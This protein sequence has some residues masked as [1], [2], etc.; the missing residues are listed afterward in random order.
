MDVEPAC[1]QCG[2]PLLDAAVFCHRC[3]HRV[4][5][6][7]AP[8]VEAV[9]AAAPAMPQDPALGERRF[10][11][12]AVL[13]LVGYTAICSACDAED[14]QA[15]LTRFFALAD[16]TIL[17][18]GGHVVDHAGDAVIA[19]FGAPVAHGDDALRA[20]RAVLGLQARCGEV[21]DP[22]GRP[23]RLHAGCSSG[24]V[25]VSTISVGGRPQISVTGETLNVAARLAGQAGES[26]TLLS[27]RC[28]VLVEDRIDA[29]P[30][31][32]L[33]LKGLRAP[34]RAWRVHGLG[35]H[36]GASTRLLGRRPEL[37]CWQALLARTQGCDA[38]C[39]VGLEGPAGIGKSRLLE[40]FSGLASSAGHVV[41]KVGIVDFG[42]HDERQFLG[43]ILRNLSGIRPSATDSDAWQWTCD[44]AIAAESG[45]DPADAAALRALLRT[46]FG[47]P[48]D[49]SDRERLAAVPYATR[50]AW[51][52]DALASALAAASRERPLVLAIED[53]H[54]GS[55]TAHGL[56]VRAARRAAG[57]AWIMVYTTR[58]PIAEF[59]AGASDGSRVRHVELRL[60]PLQPEACA[61]LA[62]SMRV[63]PRERDACI[64][65]SGGNPL[66]LES[67]LRA[68]RSGP[69]DG[70]PGTVQAA[71]AARV[72]RLPSEL[73]SM[74]QVASV[75]GPSVSDE[76]LSRFCGAAAATA[77]VMDA[78]CRSGLLRRDGSRIAFGH[79][80]IHDAVYASLLNSRRRQ[81]HRSIADADLD[82]EPSL[83]AEHLLRAGDPRAAQA[84]LEAAR[85]ALAEHDPATAQTLAARG[86]T[87][88]P[89]PITLARLSIVRGSALCDIGR[90]AEAWG[91]L[92]EA[93]TI[94]AGR[95][96]L[97]EVTLA[98]VEVARITGRFDEAH[99]L[100]DSIE[101]SV[102]ASG[103]RVGI[104]SLHTLRGALL[105]AQA[106]PAESLA[107]HSRAKEAALESG[108]AQALIRA[109]SG[110]GDAEYGLGRWD[111][112]ASRFSE[113]YRLARSLGLHRHALPAA[114]MLGLV[115]M[116]QLR[117]Q[118]A[119]ETIERAL[120]EA[121]GRSTMLGEVVALNMLSRIRQVRGDL[122]D[123]E[124]HAHRAIRLA[125]L[126][127]ANRLESVALTLLASALVLSDRRSE[128]HAAALS[129]LEL[130][131]QYGLSFA[132]PN[133]F[134][135]I[136]MS[137]SS[138]ADRE[139]ARSE[140]EAILGRSD[141]VHAHIAFRKFAI[142]SALER[143]D[144]NEA[145]RH[146]AE[147]EAR[148]AP[149]G[150]AFVD[151]LVSRARGLADIGRA[152][153]NVESRR[154]L[155]ELVERIRGSG[156]L[157]LLGA[158]L[159][160]VALRVGVV[161]LEP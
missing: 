95:E 122:Q 27:D 133:A 63:D 7:G 12:C 111:D 84:F 123:A 132:G 131:R 54:W 28:H 42:V 109:L 83:R 147:L 87:A 140:G 153:A 25:V 31:E 96:V 6:L 154:C 47:L 33:M 113:A 89:A 15:M 91:L 41:R 80:L 141:M 145:I 14:V 118:P 77:S 99:A 156:A 55:P 76:Q 81:L 143:S 62:D 151:L 72:D 5:R 155:R 19:T 40:A 129:S 115:R 142:E 117:L 124:A 121:D 49:P 58:R 61:E 90:T 79:A 20:I 16:R 70:V 98:A 149:G 37:E 45:S 161:G 43:D 11:T 35:E 94:P 1:D 146:A 119:T 93:L 157:S 150:T 107:A 66:F 68:T 65:R 48:A 38:P 8:E 108:D 104:A 30:I 29:S 152:G 51:L 22:L 56:L 88:A 103:D 125:R 127:R 100:L 137:A 128:A 32:G 101:R 75:F 86:G 23:L 9:P 74:L 136:V 120:K 130:S 78:L 4:A 105:F 144:W 34:V 148:V 59:Q 21:L 160:T 92:Q 10:A 73:R 64:A 102:S 158:G 112:A 18:A 3:G 134:G 36:L 17:D 44:V 135:L 26:E 82:L 139:A 110:V 53:L 2:T 46:C 13:D 71:V 57:G 24:E 50:E 159:R 69:L 97:H 106:R 67:L 116:Y 114:A 39:L 52:A 85:S 138:E 60:D 126:L